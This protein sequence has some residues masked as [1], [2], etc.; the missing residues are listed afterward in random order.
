ME[1][2]SM[3]SKA[4]FGPGY[5]GQIP[6]GLLSRIKIENWVINTWVIQAYDQAT[7]TVIT[8]TLRSLVNSH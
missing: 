2:S 6:A 1:C 7:S 5:P 8:V 3:V 4:T